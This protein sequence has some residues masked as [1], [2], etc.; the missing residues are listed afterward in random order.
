MD[1]TAELVAKVRVLVT[2]RHSHGEAYV[3]EHIAKLLR[4]L[5]NAANHGSADAHAREMKVL[6]S[7]ELNCNTEYY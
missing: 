5:D 3:H 4:S 1:A 2:H 6:P 7:L